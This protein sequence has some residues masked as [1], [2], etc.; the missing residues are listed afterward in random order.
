MIP[1]PL[2]G[3]SCI[4]FFIIDPSRLF[5]EGVVLYPPI[6]FHPV[7]ILVHDLSVITLLRTVAKGA[8]YP[9]F[10]KD[11]STSLFFFRS[12]IFFILCDWRQ[13]VLDSVWHQFLSIGT[14][15]SMEARVVGVIMCVDVVAVRRCTG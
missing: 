14:E 6:R 15:G 1:D 4:S 12:A 10:F 11:D 7:V 5:G 8:G 9:D 13:F 2:A 3:V